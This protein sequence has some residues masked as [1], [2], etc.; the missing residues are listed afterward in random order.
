MTED[1]EKYLQGFTTQ[2]SSSLHNKI[3]GRS[4]KKTLMLCATA[5]A[6]LI[7]ILTVSGF[8]NTQPQQT[9]KEQQFVDKD[10]EHIRRVR[11]LHIRHQII[12]N[13]VNIE[14]LIDSFSSHTT[15]TASTRDFLDIENY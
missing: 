5:A 9:Q 11:R 4:N 14:S 10:P 7:A 13:G 15:V 1:F 8:I 6:V 2:P 3:F 12:T